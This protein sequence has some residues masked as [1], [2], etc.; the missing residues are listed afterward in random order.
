VAVL[1]F[2]PAPTFYGIHAR[3]GSTGCIHA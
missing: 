2:G 1:A 3:R